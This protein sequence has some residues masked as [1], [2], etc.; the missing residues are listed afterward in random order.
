VF[1]A[2]DTTQG[3][4]PRNRG[5]GHCITALALQQTRHQIVD[6]CQS[7]GMLLSRTGAEARG[8]ICR[9]PGS[10][11]A[12][13]FSSSLSSI[14]DFPPV[15]SKIPQQ[16][17]HRCRLPCGTGVRPGT[18]QPGGGFRS[19]RR[20]L[21]LVPPSPILALTVLWEGDLNSSNEGS[22]RL[23]HFSPLRG[24]VVP[25]LIGQT[26]SHYKVLEHLG[27]GGMGVVYEAWVPGSRG[28]RAEVDNGPHFGSRATSSPAPTP[29]IA[30]CF[31]CA[32]GLDR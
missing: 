31:F 3:R 5:S 2:A 20:W 25:N 7:M 1:P 27:G 4:A 29:G 22:G 16:A 30:A 14:F 13:W 9:K 12:I 11:D 21:I 6:A 17:T 32:P 15:P 8:G 18:R 24:F 19:V 28:S 10:E 26:V 23:F